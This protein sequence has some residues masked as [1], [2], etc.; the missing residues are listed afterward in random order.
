[1]SYPLAFT[2][3]RW[4]AWAPG[5]S[6]AEDWRCWAEN[7]KIITDD[8]S[9]PALK[10][11]K[12]MQRRRFSRLTRMAL[13]TSY[14]CLQGEHDIRTVFCSRHGEI[15]RTKALLDDIAKQE[16]I[17]PMGFSLSVHNTASGLYSI[18]SGNQAPSTAI[19]AGLDSLEM[20]V[21]EALGQLQ[22][23]PH[24][25][26]LVVIAD[27]PFPAFYATDDNE[28]SCPYSVAMLLAADGDGERYQLQPLAGEPGQAL[29]RQLPHG[30]QLLGLISGVDNVCLTEGERT[31]WQ[32]MRVE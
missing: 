21:I 8:D 5:L 32:W 10:F 16:L 31:Q 14:E 1:M 25:P 27:E 30:L 24:Q 19:A 3:L 11:I 26:V 9:A 6:C 20:A 28:L 15:H 17:S 22:S 18:A 29:Q 12:P 7:K 23:N 4:A 13:Q 2:V